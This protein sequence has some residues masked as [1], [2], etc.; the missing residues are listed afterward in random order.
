MVTMGEGSARHGRDGSELWLDPREV[1][2]FAP[3]RG[4]YPWPLG[5]LSRAVASVVPEE[6]LL[7]ADGL[8]V[9]FPERGLR[10]RPRARGTGAGWSEGRKRRFARRFVPA[11]AA[12]LSA[13]VAGTWVARQAEPSPAQRPDT[14]LRAAPPAQAPVAPVSPAPLRDAPATLAP[15]PEATGPNPAARDA[16]AVYPKIHWRQSRAIGL[17]HAGRLVGG[18]RLPVEGPD[19]VTWDP[20][21][22]RV[23]NRAS[24]LYGTD[25]LVRL[26]I[27]VVEEYRRA[28]PDAPRVV[29][30]DLSH[31][32]G[33]AINEHASHENGLDV[34]IYYPRLDHRLAAPKHVRL[35]DRQLAQDLAD[36][37]VRAG[38]TV[39]F[40]GYRTGLRGPAGVVV[41]YAGHDNHMHVRIASARGGSP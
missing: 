10:A 8:A 14:A 34:D 4:R 29:I 36:R 23:P 35:V 19:W 6:P 16:E 31:R 26:V 39:V 40:V 38:A 5:S 3:E 11:V 22:H 18:V 30:G 12:V 9:A 24:R 21:L 2:W 32:R 20:V 37:F 13:A 25:D 27:T 7:A 41:P 17:P 1:V 15:L 33:G 28:H